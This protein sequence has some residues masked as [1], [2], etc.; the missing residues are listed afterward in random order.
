MSTPKADSVSVG[1]APANSEQQQPPA[2]ASILLVD[3]Q[4]ARLLSYEAILYGLGVQCV[5][6]LS[7][8]QALERLLEQEISAGA[9]G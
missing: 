7:G 2:R 4:P 1:A 3:D 6:A 5:R 8:T 9:Q